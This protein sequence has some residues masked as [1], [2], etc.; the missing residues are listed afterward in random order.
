MG[1]GMVARLFSFLLPHFF[2]GVFYAGTYSLEKQKVL[3]GRREKQRRWVTKDLISALLFP[4][5]IEHV[6]LNIT[7]SLSFLFILQSR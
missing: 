3:C 4:D 6:A 2:K 7:F 1:L 5:S